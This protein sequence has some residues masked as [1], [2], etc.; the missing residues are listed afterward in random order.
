[1][2]MRILNVS[3]IAKN[4]APLV[5]AARTAEVSI[6]RFGAFQETEE[7]VDVWAAVF[8]CFLSPLQQKKF[9]GDIFTKKTSK[10]MSQKMDL[11]DFVKLFSQ[12]YVRED[13]FAAFCRAVKGNGTRNISLS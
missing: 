1:M 13:G 7:A 12:N 11:M 8:V 2:A 6:R 4:N 3:S 10:T 9:P 5:F